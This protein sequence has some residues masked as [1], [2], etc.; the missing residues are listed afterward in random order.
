MD[1]N[2][3]TNGKRFPIRKRVL[4]AI[5][6]LTIAVLVVSVATTMVFM[7]NM[8]HTSEVLLAEELRT[9]LVREVELKASNT[10][11]M[12]DQYKAYLESLRDYVQN[13]YWDY[14]KLVA[15]GKYIDAP[16]AET[17]EGVYALQSAYYSED[18]DPASYHD[19][20]YFLS[21]LERIMD[22]IARE[23][24]DVISTVYLGTTDGLLV[25]YDRWSV[26]SAVP[27]PGQMIYD[28]FKSAWYQEG[29]ASEDIIFTSLYVD[30]QGRGLTITTATP[31]D[32]L[33]GKPQGVFAADF[34]ITGMYNEMISMDFGVGSTA[35]AI[36][37]TG[38]LISIES[39]E[40]ILAKDYLGLPT[41]VFN[42]MTSGD[43]GIIE[44]EKAF[45]AYSHVDDVDWTLCAMVP[46]SILLGKVD[47]ILT[48]FRNAMLAFVLIAVAL[49]LIAAYVSNRFARSI[50]HP[51]ELLEDDMEQI[52]AG[53]LDHKAVAY[54]NDEIGDMT[55]SLNE[56]VDRLKHTISELVTAEKRADEMHELANKDALTG[57][58]NKGAYDNYL[59][60]LQDKVDSKNITEFALGVFDCDNLKLINDH[61]GHDKGDEYLKAAANLICEVFVHSPVFRIGGDEFAVA[62]TGHDY[63]MRD[64]LAK[65]FAEEQDRINSSVENK[66]EEVCVALGIAEYD[67]MN[68]HSVND[69][70]RRA[71]K[72]MYENKRIRKME[73]NIN[74]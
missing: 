24:E 43:T 28:Y 21:H 40:E 60:E 56:M 8:M 2:Q 26:L 59:S 48:S 69:T 64:K 18:A 7:H 51:I 33:N 13:M 30:S 63:Q 22:S 49:L 44:T 11:I 16:R 41:D 35:F 39:E 9:S 54:H 65:H 66:W 67:P 32:D 42:L 38:K 14:D 3:Q 20:M 31:Y 68:D 46:R 6:G 70:A 23:N 34:D 62:L 72:V 57:L 71:D 58:R 37:K 74:M 5:L 61:Y 36:D 17:G 19:E 27:Y 52:A 25:S 53:D 45:Y 50:T 10:D 73:S 47:S 4:A 12:L 55:H 1:T 15:T 29:I